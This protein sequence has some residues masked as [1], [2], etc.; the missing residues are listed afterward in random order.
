MARV[1]VSSGVALAAA[2]VIVVGAACGSFA[3]DDSPPDASSD[4][5]VESGGELLDAPAPDGAATG[6]GCTVLVEDSFD[7]PKAS[8][9]RWRFLGAARITNGEV[10]LVPDSG[11]KAG[12]IW[13]NVKDAPPGNLRARFTS[14]IA[15]ADGSDGLTFAWSANQDVTLGGTAGSY[16][17]C[18][19]GADGLA[20]VLASYG[21]SVKLLDVTNKCESDGGIPANVFGTT[22]VVVAASADRV[23]A[24]ISDRPYLF[25][26]P[27]PVRVR[28]VGFTAAT[29]GG[30][31]RHAIDDVRIEICAL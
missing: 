26:A 10:E 14:K 23:E 3:A 8:A 27:R 11:D 22:A 15:P 28:S 19:G 4:A 17:L 30:H 31:A 6:N 20:L 9:A 24:T 12:A 25:E 21:K 29:G 16:G 1:V 7:D 5:Q 18:G 13:I 2:A